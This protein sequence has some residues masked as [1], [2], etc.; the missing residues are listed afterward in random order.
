MLAFI[1]IRAGLIIAMVACIVLVGIYL[2]YATKE[3]RK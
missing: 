3:F 1:D 2:L